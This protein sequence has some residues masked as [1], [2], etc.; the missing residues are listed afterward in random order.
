MTPQRHQ[1]SAPFNNIFQQINPKR[2]SM[3]SLFKLC[4]LTLVASLLMPMMPALAQDLATGMANSPNPASGKAPR[5]TPEQRQEYARAQEL[6]SQDNEY[7][8]AVQRAIEAQKI[9]DR[10][11]FTKMLRAAPELRE[12]ITYLQ[13]ARG[14]SQAA[15]Q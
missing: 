13:T 14:L 11:F 15:E 1:P 3:T 5:L 2:T 10:I 7:K 8:A 4:R 12:Y 9:A 6:V